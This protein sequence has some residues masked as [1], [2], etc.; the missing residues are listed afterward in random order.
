M[1]RQIKPK[2]NYKRY[3][4]LLNEIEHFCHGLSKSESEC[5]QRCIWLTHSFFFNKIPELENKTHAEHL[6][7]RLNMSSHEFSLKIAKEF[8]E[9]RMNE[10]RKK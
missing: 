9:F 7:E 10:L 5:V 6:S 8:N 4:P 1:T 2:L 3:K